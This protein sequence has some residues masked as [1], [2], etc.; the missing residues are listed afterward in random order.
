MQ[1]GSRGESFPLLDDLSVSLS[2]HTEVLVV[3]S[4]ETDGE[5][6]HDDEPDGEESQ[7]VSDHRTEHQLATGRHR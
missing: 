2:H 5:R 4:V 7:C 1:C 6:Q 3:Q